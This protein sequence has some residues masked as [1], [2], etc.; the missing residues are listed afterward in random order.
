VAANTGDHRWF[1]KL[2]VT[3]DAFVVCVHNGYGPVRIS[4]Y[5]SGFT[6]MD[7]LH[8]RYW[9]GSHAHIEV[10]ILKFIYLAKKGVY[11]C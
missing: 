9:G 8:R 11:S 10:F 5:E 2:Q 4:H 7:E 6:A 3:H 1:G